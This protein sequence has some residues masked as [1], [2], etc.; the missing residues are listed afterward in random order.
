MTGGNRCLGEKQS[1]SGEAETVV[2][3]LDV[4]QEPTLL[5]RKGLSRQRSHQCKGP[6]SGACLPR[7]Q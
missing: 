4:G 1:R 7:A 2:T 3:L 6:E 5:I